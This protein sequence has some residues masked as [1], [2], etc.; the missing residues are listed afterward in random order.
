MNKQEFLREIAA[1]AGLTIKD[2]GAFYEAYVE[3]V[4]NQLKKGNKI[5]LVGFG[6]YSA[7]KRAARTAINPRTKEKIAVKAT[8]VPA[9]KFGKAF[10]EVIA[11]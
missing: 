7:R 6:T 9:L 11:K 2:A 4:K 10:K 3:T 5:V 1:T 8:T